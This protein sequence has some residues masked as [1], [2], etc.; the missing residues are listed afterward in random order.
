M[1]GDLESATPALCRLQLGTD[2]RRLRQRADMKATAVAKRLLWSPSKITRLEKGENATVEL[3]DVMALCELYGADAET[4]ALLVGYAT[5]TKT[6]RDWWQTPE[7]SPVIRP[8]L[9]A[10]LGQEA[11]ATAM[12]T[13]ESEFVP[14]L[15]QTE[16]YVRA[17][18]ETALAGLTH[19]DVER[20]VS[21]RMTRQSVLHRAP[22]PLKLVAIINEAVL[23][24]KVGGPAV[25]RQQLAHIAEVSALP[26]VRVQVVPFDLGVHPGMNGPFAIIHF[27]KD[28]DLR[29]IVYVEN[30]AD[31]WVTRQLHDVDKY[32]EAFN[33]LEAVAPSPRESLSMIHTAIKEL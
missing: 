26:N 30:L 19:E 13:Y 17:I 15:L 5:V 32:E 1:T 20:T 12:H 8:G 14:G 33:N 16:D 4:R 21:I 23:R 2:L 11:A 25:T 9:K 3:T 18:H 7:F 31:A 28:D 29:P 22:S 6:R 24:R 27:S 10:L